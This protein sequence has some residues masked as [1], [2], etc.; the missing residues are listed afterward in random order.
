MYEPLELCGPMTKCPESEGPELLQC[1][2]WPLSRNKARHQNSC[3]ANEQCDWP[4]AKRIQVYERKD[5]CSV[6]FPQCDWALLKRIQA[7][8][9]KDRCQPQELV[10]C[11]W[12]LVKQVQL[13]EHEERCQPKD[14]SLQQCDWPLLKRIQLFEA[15]DL[16]PLT[17][18]DACEWPLLKQLQLFES[19][20][21]S[22][23]QRIC[24]CRQR[25]T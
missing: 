4:R 11:E 19:E 2:W 15:Q 17:N 1:V 20:D 8:E 6:G 7:Y 14:Y 9:D 23:F 13:Y 12:P 24:R 18:P 21:S 5:V 16:C 3:E 25:R 22:S 10:Q